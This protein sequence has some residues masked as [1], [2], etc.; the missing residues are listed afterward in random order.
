MSIESNKD[1]WD[2]ITE[3]LENFDYYDD[4]FA[5]FEPVEN[6]DPYTDYYILEEN[7]PEVL[8]NFFEKADKKNWMFLAQNTTGNYIWTTID[9][10]KTECLK[11]Y[12]S[13]RKFL[14]EVDNKSFYV[15]YDYDKEQLYLVHD[16]ENFKPNAPNP[17]TLKHIKIPILLYEK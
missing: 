17:L 5:I 10:L 1:L 8:G 16:P 11:E 14:L 6:Q 9:L 15:E 13:K 3:G 2:L 4:T 12:Y 7:L